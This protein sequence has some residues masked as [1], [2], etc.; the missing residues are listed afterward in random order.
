M[1]A[2]AAGL[3]RDA[4][5]DELGAL[6]AEV[7]GLPLLTRYGVTAGGLERELGRA[8]GAGEGL[9]VATAGETDRPVGFAWFLLRGTFARGGYLRL[10]ALAPGQERRGL[11]GQLLDEVERRVAAHS[12]GLFLLVSD[13]NEP[14]QR[15]YGARGYQQVGRLP[16]FVRP[17]IDE[18]IY[19]KPL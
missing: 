2:A 15:F 14:A 1:P 4:R 19:H 9:I 3:V 17:D 6:T 8:L 5:A 13:F 16:A 18:L 11:G 10:I 7:A 12:R